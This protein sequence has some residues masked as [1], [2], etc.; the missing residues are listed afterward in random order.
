VLFKKAE[1]EEQTI[2]SVLFI[3]MSSLLRRK[4]GRSQRL[5]GD[6]MGRVSE[7]GKR[8]ENGGPWKYRKG[9]RRKNKVLHIKWRVN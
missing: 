8:D 3:F 4:W 7:I 2:E 1:C 9:R 5:E 6:E